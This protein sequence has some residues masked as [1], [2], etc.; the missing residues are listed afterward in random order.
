MMGMM[1]YGSGFM[2][3]IPIVFLAL[4]MVGIYYFVP[5][6]PTNGRTLYNHDQNALEILK[7]RYARGEITREQYLRMKGELEL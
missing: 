6:S 3:L 2:F 7:E 4:V 5:R 1:G